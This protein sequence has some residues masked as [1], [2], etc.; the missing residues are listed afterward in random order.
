MRRRR[1]L[2]FGIGG[3]ATA[4]TA[5]LRDEGGPRPAAFVLDR[6]FL[7]TREHA[8]LPVVAFDEVADRCPPGRHLA[9]APLGYRAMAGHRADVCARFEALGYE[10]GT[11][12]SRAAS[13]W[14]GLE[15]RPNTIVL[16]NATVLPYASLGRDV[17]V[18][19]NAVVSH[20]CRLGD[21]VTVANG[22]VLGGEVTVGE[23]SW[24][25]LAAVVRDGVTLAPRTLVGAG[26]AVVADTEEDG[27]YVGVPA[28][29][30]PDVSATARTSA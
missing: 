20:H 27:V 1:V 3:F 7:T 24:V 13:V 12:V 19:P 14:R 28:R 17:A 4:F 25:G 21:H 26:A 23:R 15:L 18:R 29:R 16:P 30:L 5:L 9:F 2:V 11:W 6:P 8:G 22:A 10:L